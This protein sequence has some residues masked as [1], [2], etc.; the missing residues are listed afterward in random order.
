MGQKIP[1][2]TP[3][4]CVWQ[5]IESQLGFVTEPIQTNVV[6]I[7]KTKPR[8]WQSIAGLVSAAAIVLTVMLFSV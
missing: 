7:T 8:I 6:A 2:V 3:D 1:P 5:R 4:V